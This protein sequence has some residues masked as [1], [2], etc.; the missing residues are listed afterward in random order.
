MKMNHNLTPWHLGIG[1]EK[2]QKV[3]R[4]LFEEAEELEEV[5]LYRDKCRMK[6]LVQ[7]NL[8]LA[9]KCAHLNNLSCA[10]V[11]LVGD[12][13]LVV[14]RTDSNGIC[15]DEVNALVRVEKT[16]ETITV[17]KWKPTNDQPETNSPPE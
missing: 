3:V 13:V 14:M 5:Y 8:E 7:V 9:R 17:T 2:F 6:Y 16:T 10:P 1:T 4:Y 12:W 15:W 11:H